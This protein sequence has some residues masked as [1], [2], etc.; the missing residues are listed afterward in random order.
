[1][2]GL[3]R[4]MWGEISSSS[5][6]KETAL[7]A[8]SLPPKQVHKTMEEIIAI[9]ASNN[10]QVKAKCNTTVAIFLDVTFDL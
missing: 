9:F 8:C 3:G 5:W 1:M 6:G 2:R 10:L 7:F 4:H